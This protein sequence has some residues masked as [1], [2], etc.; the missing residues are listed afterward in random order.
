M[1]VAEKKVQTRAINQQDTPLG[2]NSNLRPD[3]QKNFAVVGCGFLQN[4][5]MCGCKISSLKS[6]STNLIG[7][8]NLD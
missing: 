4:L 2:K 1:R 5:E 6:M 8:N 7:Q 3:T